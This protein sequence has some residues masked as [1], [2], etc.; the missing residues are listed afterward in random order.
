[1]QTERILSQAVLEMDTH[2]RHRSYSEDRDVV[3]LSFGTSKAS[4]SIGKFDRSKPASRVSGLCL[5]TSRVAFR[6]TLRL[7]LAD[8]FGIAVNGDRR[9]DIAISAHS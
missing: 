8:I 5:V 6:R 7:R 3:L 4:H 9:E 1:M 2:V